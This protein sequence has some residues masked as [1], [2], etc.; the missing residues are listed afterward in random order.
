MPGACRVI[1]TLHLVTVFPERRA[2]LVFAATYSTNS[3]NARM[4]LPSGTL[5]TDSAFRSF[6]VTVSGVSRRSILLSAWELSI[7]MY[8]EVSSSGMCERVTDLD[9]W[10]SSWCLAIYQTGVSYVETA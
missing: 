6:L 3:T 4:P 2:A 5:G 10:S 7:I 1:H 8:A 9:H